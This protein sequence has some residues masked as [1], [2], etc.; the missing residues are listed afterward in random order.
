MANEG[1]ESLFQTQMCIPYFVVRNARNRCGPD[2]RITELCLPILAHVLFKQVTQERRDP[3][4]RVHA[5]GYVS[6]RNFF[7]FFIGPELLPQRARH[8]SMFATHTVGG[9]AH[10]NSQRCES[11]TLRSVRLIDTTQR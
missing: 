3:G 7:E 10:A 11:I 6:D 2:V 9:P 8:F 5:V 4:R 1:N